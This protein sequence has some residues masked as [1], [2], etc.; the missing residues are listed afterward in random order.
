MKRVNTRDPKAK[1]FRS[2]AEPTPDTPLRLD[3]KN[4]PVAEIR[5]LQKHARRKPLIGAAKGTF[6]VPESFFE[7]LPEETLK[8]FGG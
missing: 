4:Q 1:L 3:D 8:A 5:S 6:E 7:P 2:L